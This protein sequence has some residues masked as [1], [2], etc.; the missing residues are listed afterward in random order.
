MQA[1]WI[2]RIAL[3]TSYPSSFFSNDRNMARQISAAYEEVVERVGADVAHPAKHPAQL[4]GLDFLTNHLVLSCGVGVDS[5]LD[6]DGKIDARYN[7]GKWPSAT[8]VHAECCVLAKAYPVL[9]M[10]MRL[11]GREVCELNKGDV[12]LVVF[13]LSNG[14]IATDTDATALAKLAVDTPSTTTTFSFESML[15]QMCLASS[16]S[17]SRLPVRTQDFANLLESMMRDSK[18]SESGGPDY[19]FDSADPDG[20]DKVFNLRLASMM[21]HK[22]DDDVETG[23]GNDDFDAELLQQYQVTRE[24]IERQTGYIQA[25]QTTYPSYCRWRSTSFLSRVEREQ[26]LVYNFFFSIAHSLGFV[27]L[28]RIMGDL[29]P[30]QIQGMFSN[31]PTSPSPPDATR[32]IHVPASASGDRPA[33]WLP[34]NN[35]DPLRFFQLLP[36]A[37]QARLIGYHRSMHKTKL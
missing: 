31:K 28:P 25:W 15:Q 20:S 27:D 29:S 11:F 35:E 6:W 9:D 33:L 26:A 5:W 18:A 3:Q 16:S 32:P 13:R 10:E 7:L 12:P 24:Q 21:M 14:V 1:P 4:E 36:A 19:Q 22:K 34:R 23:K 37:C 30:E 8:E 2:A 17:E